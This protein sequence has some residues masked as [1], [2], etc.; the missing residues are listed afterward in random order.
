MNRKEFLII[1]FTIFLT[2][3]AW[4]LSD[5]YHAAR[6]RELLKSLPSASSFE[7][8]FDEKVFDS[9]KAKTYE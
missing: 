2:V 7:M 8:K 9:L 5:I 4:V 3:L 6:M 1:S